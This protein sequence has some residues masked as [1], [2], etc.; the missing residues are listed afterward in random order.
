MSGVNA[1][2]W[3]FAAVV[4]ELVLLLEYRRQLRE[5][6]LLGAWWWALGA[7][8]GLAAVEIAAILGVS[9]VA[10]SVESLRFLTGAMTFAPLMSVLGAKRPQHRAWHFVVLS[11]WGVVALPAIENLVL[12]PEQSLT[13]PGVRSLFLM[14]LIMVGVINWLPT[15]LG[16]AAVLF[17]AGQVL[18]FAPYTPFLLNA[19]PD[20]S[21]AYA[22]ACWVSATAVARVIEVITQRMRKPGYN[23]LWRDFRDRFGVLWGVRVLE[24]INAATI[25]NRWAI[26]LTWA[27]FRQTDGGR[28]NDET[29]IAP[30]IAPTMDT[31]IDNLLRRFVTAEWIAKRRGRRVH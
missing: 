28:T 23:R 18:W 3:V 8:M 12:H 27:G 30:E 5:T 15:P 11:M 16:P 14:G 24:R 4:L 17:G 1:T 6:T 22:S 7:T 13:L 9:Q 2:I 19:A 10:A 29:P 20:C 31:V 26:R 21:N 25:S